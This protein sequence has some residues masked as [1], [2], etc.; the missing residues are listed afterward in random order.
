MLRTTV[1]WLAALIVAIA[2]SLAIAPTA[3][4]DSD[5]DSINRYD[6]R[7]DLQ[8]DGSLDVTLDFD[9]DFGSDE[10]HGPYLTLPERMEIKGDSEHWRSLPISK[11][12]ASSRTAPAETEVEREG[13]AAQIKVGDPDKEIGG[14]HTYRVTY[15]IGGVVNPRATGS[16]LDELSWNVIGTEWEIPVRNVHVDISTPA[17]IERVECFT[18]SDYRTP[19]QQQPTETGKSASFR[20]GVDLEP[21]NGLQVVAG[22]PAGSFPGVHPILTERYTA[23]RVLGMNPVSGGIGAVLLAA[24]AAFAIWLVRRLG[25]DQRYAGIAPGQRPAEGEAADVE[26]SRS[27]PV[28]VQFHPPRGVR[29]GQIGVLADAT[30]DQEDVTAT[31]IDLATRGYLRIEEVGEDADSWQLVS[32]EQARDGLRPYESGLLDDLFAEDSTVDLDQG[33]IVSASTKCQQALYREVTD[34]LGWYRGNPSK[35]RSRWVLAGVGVLAVG[36]A[37]FFALGFTVGLG[38][39]GVAVGVVG[40]LVMILAL[41]A[42]GRTADGTAVHDQALGFKEYLETAEADQIRFEEGEDIFSRYLPYAMVWGLAERWTK[43]FAEL[44]DRGVDLPAPSWYVGASVWS[45]SGSGG[46]SFV[47]A[48]N[49]FD[50][51]AT[52]AMTSA[53]SGSGGGSG[54]SGGGGVGGGG[55]GGW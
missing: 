11:I 1:R 30:A 45:F 14:K 22:M 6:V 32:T 23:G 53:S 17:E 4:A 36:I 18:G 27:H 52:S 51:A 38:L 7:A 40:I 47:E 46:S 39:I 5:D 19:C 49:G 28:A 35:I 24:G 42:A 8:S 34:E 3:Q 31:V 54:F 15:T 44:A 50:A 29:P 41:K 20:P 43:T 21:G 48:M 37:L 9:F 33:G 26:R 16:D 2:V 13:G 55:G 25:G 10:G 12:S